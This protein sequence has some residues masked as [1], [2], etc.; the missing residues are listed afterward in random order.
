MIIPR[1]VKNVYISWNSSTVDEY[2]SFDTHYT[3]ICNKLARSNFI[4]SRVKNILPVKSLKTLY[5]SP[6]TPPPTLL[7]PNFHLHDPKKY[8]KS[9]PNAKESNQASHKV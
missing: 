3:L 8:Q 4:I 1:K 9:L 7:P 2:L 6:I 5:F